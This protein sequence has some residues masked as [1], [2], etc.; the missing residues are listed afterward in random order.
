MQVVDEPTRGHAVPDLLHMNK[1]E[2]M[3]AVK[4]D[5]HLDHW[6]IIRLDKRAKKAVLSTLVNEDGRFQCAEVKH[7]WQKANTNEGEQI[8]PDQLLCLL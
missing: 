5:N 1:E 6:F 4:T 3:E 8:M 7:L 2:L